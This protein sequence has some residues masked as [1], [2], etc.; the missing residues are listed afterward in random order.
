MGKITLLMAISYSF[1]TTGFIYFIILQ[2]AVYNNKTTPLNESLVG[3][4]STGTG[5]QS[6]ISLM[7]FG[8]PMLVI[9]LLR[10]AFGEIISQLVLLAIGLAL[11][12]TS[13]Y[14]IMNIYKRF[15][16]RR[17]KNMEGFRDTK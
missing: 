4:Q 1:F 14:W 17:Y 7:S 10:I 11:T 8:V 5:F 16:K 3:R 15:M 9:N 6:L 13:N 12:F 2:L